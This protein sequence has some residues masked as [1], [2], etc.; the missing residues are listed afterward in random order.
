MGGVNLGRRRSVNRRWLRVL[1]VAG[2]AALR[3]GLSGAKHLPPYAVISIARRSLI[4]PALARR[5]YI[6]RLRFAHDGIVLAALPPSLLACAPNQG[7]GRKAE[8]IT[9]AIALWHKLPG[10]EFIGGTLAFA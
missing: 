2:S 8:P 4:G 3:I 9:T 5:C 7:V 6:F 10:A 1:L